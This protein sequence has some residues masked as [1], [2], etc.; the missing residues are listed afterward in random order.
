MLSKWKSNAVFCNLLMR[1]I[2]SLPRRLKNKHF[3][4]FVLCINITTRP[5]TSSNSIFLPIS[6][7]FSPSSMPLHFASSWTSACCGRTNMTSTFLRELSRIISTT[8]QK[9]RKIWF[10]SAPFKDKWKAFWLLLIFSRRGNT[11]LMTLRREKWRKCMLIIA[12]LISFC[13]NSTMLKTKYGWVMSNRKKRMILSCWLTST[14]HSKNMV[15][16]ILTGLKLKGS[17]LRK[18]MQSRTFLVMIVNLTILLWITTIMQ[19][20]KKLLNQKCL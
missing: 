16:L 13:R 6:Y 3:M 12:F 10:M 18:K 5:N 14:P 17:K 19:K 15:L 20:W 2:Y 9:R 8:I 7:C 1:S 4:S 11:D